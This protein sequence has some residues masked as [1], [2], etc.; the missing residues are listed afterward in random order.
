M[1]FTD[2]REVYLSPFKVLLMTAKGI[3]NNDNLTD[4]D[5][6]IRLEEL[7]DSLESEITELEQGE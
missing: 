4:K 6:L 7:F 3:M 2:F 1:K 5:K